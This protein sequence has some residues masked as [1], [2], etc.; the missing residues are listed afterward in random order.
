VGAGTVIVVGDTIDGRSAKWSMSAQELMDYGTTVIGTDEACAFF[1]WRYDRNDI[2]YFGRPDI[3]AA[4]V[5]LANLA[6]DRTATSC[7]A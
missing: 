7:V 1:M 6:A 5:D 4:V 3:A 2:V